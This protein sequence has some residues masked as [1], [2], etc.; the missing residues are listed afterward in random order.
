MLESYVIG[1]LSDVEVARVEAHVMECS[2]CAARLR[3]EAELDI[4]FEAVVS[5]TTT[6]SRTRAPA[7]TMISSSVVLGTALAMAAAV[8]L[9]VMPRGDAGSTPATQEPAPYADTEMN[10][11]ASTFTASLDV[12]ADGSRLGVKD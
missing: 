5:S 9:W 3:R 11:D 4:A 6:P 10:A 2:A 1:A 8:F 7:V 12:Q